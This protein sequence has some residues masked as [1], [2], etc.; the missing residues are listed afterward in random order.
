MP[1]TPP[2]RPLSKPAPQVAMALLLRGFPECSAII[3]APV[4]AT[5]PVAVRIRPASKG[6]ESV[7]PHGYSNHGAGVQTQNAA[8]VDFAKT[9]DGQQQGQWQPAE[10]HYRHS[11]GRRKNQDGYRRCD[12]RKAE[13]RH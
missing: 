3:P 1:L 5:R 12:H 9:V 11:L 4:K 13:A 6:R 2:I 8:G 7:D 10:D